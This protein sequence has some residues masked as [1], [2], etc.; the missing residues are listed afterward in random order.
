MNKNIVIYPHNP[1]NDA[2]GGITVQYYLAALLDNLGI[3][4]KICNNHY[5]TKNNN[6]FNKFID[7][8]DIDIENT[9]VIY[10]E[11]I[12]GNPLNAKYVVRWILS[13]LGQNVSIDNYFTWKNTDLIY[14]FNSEIELIEKKIDFKMLS[15]FYLNNNIKNCRNERKGQCYTNRKYYI[16]PKINKIH[17]DDSFEITKKHTQDE[18]IEIFNKCE[19]FISYDPITFLILISA[20]CGCVSIIYPIEGISKQEYFKMTPLYEYLLE[21]NTKLY[22]IAYG[23]TDSEINFAKTTVHLAK[24]QI[25]DIQKWFIKKYV[26]NFIEDMNNFD[27]NKNNFLYYISINYFNK[28]ICH[29]NSDNVEF[30][31]EFYKKN[32]SDLQE[33]SIYKLLHHYNYYGKKEGRFA[34]EKEVQ[35]F[36]DDPDFDIDFYIKYNPDLNTLSYNELIHHYKN[37]GKKEGRFASE[38]QLIDFIGDTDFNVDF[39]IKYN[40]DLNTLSYKELIHH[41]KKYGKREGRISSKKEVMN[42]SQDPYFDLE[43]YIKIYGENLIGLTF[44]EIKEYY[45]NYGLKQRHFSSKKQMCDYVNDTDFDIDFYRKYNLDLIGNIRNHLLIEHYKDYG[46]KMNLICSEKKLKYFAE[47][48]IVC[49]PLDEYRVLSHVSKIKTQYLSETNNKI[50]EI[51]NKGII[52]HI[53][54]TSDTEL[55]TIYINW[56][57]I[58]TE[59][60]EM[61][62]TSPISNKLIYT[63]KYFILCNN[64]HETTK[65]SICNYYFEDEKIILGLGLGTGNHPQECYILYIYSLNENKIFY[66]WLNYSFENFKKN[67]MVRIIDFIYTNM[68]TYE[69]N[70]INSQVKT[71]Y[72][73][74]NNIGH[75]LFNEY[76]GLYILNDCNLVKNINEVIQGPFDVYHVS[77]YFSNL[78]NI[79]I[80]YV[81]N[82]NILNY[83]IGKGILFK[84]HHH[85]ITDNCIQFLENNLDDVYSKINEYENVKLYS[86]KIKQTYYPIINIVLRKGDY[87]MNE[88][89]TVISNLINMIVKKYPNAFFYFDGFVSNNSTEKDVFLGIN[90]NISI[91]KIKNDYINLVNEIT[92]KICTDNYLSL[93]DTNIRYLTTYIKNST[94]AIYTLS[95]ASCNGAWIY[96]IPGI[97]FG[98]PSIHIYIWIDKIIRDGKLDINYYNDNITYDENGN[99][100]ISAQTIF[101]LLPNF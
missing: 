59:T 13:K 64:E 67:N 11:G 92:T 29:Y 52:P 70:K 35:D 66:G 68:K 56:F 86:E 20:M 89:S 71:I 6:I 54:K 17:I 100:N 7:I 84:F 1:F 2:D 95:S 14:Y 8:D 73:L 99:F 62:I 83:V 19:F 97:Q 61:V 10:S 33:I 34:S 40:P 60:K 38:K 101:D 46:K 16:H 75:S 98:R 74:S 63:D 88:Q 77:K 65:Y 36:I 53:D 25:E 18:C 26:A 72:G 49:L 30:D 96:K 48:E 93:I 23:T 57:K 45:I 21:N 50:N 41:Y 90:S 12:I 81:D 47:N 3:N 43:F 9:V 4:A 94:Y 80:N 32:N 91:K 69:F 87:E 31:V 37:Y 44:S 24:K 76:T 39:Y 82:L 5:Y 15:L 42:L 22:G 28:N 78:T 79:N 85:F 51:K 58:I 27:K 55:Y